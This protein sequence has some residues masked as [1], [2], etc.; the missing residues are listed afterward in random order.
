M[1]LPDRLRDA[2]RAL[3]NQIIDERGYLGVYLYV[4]ASFD[5]GTQTADLQPMTPAMPALSK[6]P[7]RTPGLK[8]KLVEGDQVLV[9]FEGGK[10]TAPYVASLMTAS[11]YTAAL[12]AA[13]Q[14]DMAI[15]G[16]NGV[17]ASLYPLPGNTAPS[18]LPATPYFISFGTVA[19]P[20]LP[21]PQGPLYGVVGTGST[22]VKTK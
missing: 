18:V 22:F 19:I 11:T 7:I 16:G 15:C 20:P 4:V 6:I 13:R 17:V 14:G 8:V 5:E 9:G 10:A 21:A 12:N 3:V 2:I 1:S